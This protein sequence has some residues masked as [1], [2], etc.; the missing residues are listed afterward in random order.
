[1]A[2]E[3]WALGISIIALLAALT[4]DFFIPSFF[5]PR[6]KLEGKDDGECVINNV[7]V[8]G[9][10]AR[11][12]RLRLINKDSWRSRKA[13]KCYMKLLE[14]RDSK[15]KKIMPFDQ[16]PLMWV[17]YDNTKND[18]SKGEY[19]LVDLVH[20][21][22][23]NSY[24]NFKFD[25]QIKLLKEREIGNKLGPGNYIFKVGV[26]GDNFNSFSEEFKIKIT[27]KFGELNFLK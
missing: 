9:G 17:T 19:H 21:M 3:W 1:M 12:I 8:P 26:Y 10:D 18:L 2:A 13:E 11:W 4:K 5:K 20:E 6:L 23:V 7:V 25:I 24:L 15:N 27:N 16:T 22:K 14:I